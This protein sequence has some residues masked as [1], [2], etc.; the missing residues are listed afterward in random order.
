MAPDPV[1]GGGVVALDELVDGGL[2]LGKDEVGE[3]VEQSEH[4]VEGV[5]RDG[6]RL[7]IA[8]HPV[9]VDVGVAHAQQRVLLRPPR[10]RRQ[11]QLDVG[12]DGVDVGL[13]LTRLQ[14]PSGVEDRDLPSRR[15]VRVE[16]PQAMAELN[17]GPG[18][19]QATGPGLVGDPCG[20]VGFLIARLVPAHPPLPS[21][22]R[23]GFAVLG[24]AHS[25]PAC[26]P[27]RTRS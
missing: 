2:A 5:V 17:L 18:S 20:P 11:R 19:L 1:E 15:L 12:D 10:Q 21:R 14:A 23:P 3:F 26:R 7:R 24:A 22:C 13:A 16:V 27:T 8:P 6:H 4:R 25:F 9:H